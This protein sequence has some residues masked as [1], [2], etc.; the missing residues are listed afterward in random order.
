MK[1][2]RGIGTVVGIMI[3]QLHESNNN[4]IYIFDFTPLAHGAVVLFRLQTVVRV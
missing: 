4:N 2:S 3:K 1:C